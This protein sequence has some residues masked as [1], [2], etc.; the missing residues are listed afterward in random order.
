VSLQRRGCNLH[1]FRNR[2][3][4]FIAACGGAITW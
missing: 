2:A 4:G 3:G 1:A